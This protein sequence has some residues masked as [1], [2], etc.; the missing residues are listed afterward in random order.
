MARDKPFLRV[1]RGLNMERDRSELSVVRTLEGWRHWPVY[2]SAI[3]VGTLAA[4]STALVF[5][6]MGIAVGA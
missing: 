1:G 2:W 5:G 4:L 6:L 3:W